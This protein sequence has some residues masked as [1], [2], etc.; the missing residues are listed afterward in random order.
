MNVSDSYTVVNWRDISDDL[1]RAYKL[2]KEEHPDASTCEV[3]LPWV[4]D[5]LLPV[6][7]Q[8]TIGLLRSTL[9]GIRK[10]FDRKCGSQ[11]KDFVERLKSHSVHK[12][13]IGGTNGED[14]LELSDF[15]I[16]LD[17]SVDG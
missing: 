1:T 15:V 7:T 13:R 8:F 2:T 5:G 11:W 16:E 17:S 9:F 12:V 3:G 10:D 14:E 4:A 6:E